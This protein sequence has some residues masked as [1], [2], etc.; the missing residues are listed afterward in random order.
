MQRSHGYQWFGSVF[1]LAMVLLSTGGTAWS[2]P[3]PAYTL[4][5]LGEGQVAAIDKEANVVVGWRGVDQHAFLLYPEVRDLGVLPEGTFS[6]ANGVFGGT[7]CGFS[8]TGPFGFLTHA[9]AWTLAQGLIDLGTLGDP[10]V[11]SSCTALNAGTYVGFGDDGRSTPP[12]PTVPLVWQGPGTAAP[13]PTLGGRG[14]ANTINGAGDIC[15]DSNLTQEFG[16]DTHATCWWAEDP[17][18]PVDIQTLASDFSLVLDLSNTRHAVGIV[19]TN[20]GQQGFIYDEIQGMVLVT[21]LPGDTQSTAT[22][23]NDSGDYVGSSR[24]PNPIT[25]DFTHQVAVI[26]SHV[27]Y[28]GP[29][30]L[31]TLVTNLDGR[32]LV[33]AFE[34]SNRGFIVARATKEDTEE[35]VLLVPSDGPVVQVPPD[36]TPP[37]KGHKPHKVKRQDSQDWVDCHPKL[38]IRAAWLEVRGASLPDQGRGRK[39]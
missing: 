8:S 32:T 35:L 24:L 19:S 1:M 12:G 23:I 15:G 6:Q 11:F 33:E 36:V 17:S 4:I 9:F 21:R 31:N 2:A 10:Q 28:Q 20:T 37:G 38:A 22:S 5:P 18:T 25:G 27:G 26:W 3:A 30:D 14:F 16:S 39:R 7:V 29:F 34:I 13:L